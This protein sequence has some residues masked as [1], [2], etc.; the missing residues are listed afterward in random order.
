MHSIQLHWLEAAESS[1][2][3]FYLVELL[4]RPICDRFDGS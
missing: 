4:L 2:V 1:F 3:F